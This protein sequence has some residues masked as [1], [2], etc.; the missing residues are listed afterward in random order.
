MVRSLRISFLGDPHLVD[1]MSHGWLFRASFF[2]IL[3]CSS[4]PSPPSSVFQ[5]ST[6]NNTSASWS[7]NVTH[8]STDH[9][10]SFSFDW[11]FWLTFTGFSI[12]CVSRYLTLFWYEYRC[13]LT[14]KASK[15]WAY[16]SRLWWVCTRSKICGISL[17]I[18]VCQW[19]VRSRAF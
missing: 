6:I 13:M 12:G 11:W 19:Y 4:L 16:S 1:Q 8:A 17:A 18:Y 9:P 5:S 2:W 7:L 10:R 3:C 15:W 14:N